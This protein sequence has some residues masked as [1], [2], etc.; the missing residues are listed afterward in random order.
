MTNEEIKQFSMKQA[1]K[2]AEDITHLCGKV[3]EKGLQG[4][5]RGCVEM[6]LRNNALEAKLEEF[7]NLCALGDTDETTEALGWGVLIKET[8]ALLA[9]EGKP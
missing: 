5:L 2:L 3:I 7:V 4:I 8:K 9:D 1:P 6:K